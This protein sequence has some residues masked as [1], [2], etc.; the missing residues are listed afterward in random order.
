M[1]Y[2]SMI[3]RMS[4]RRLL[5]GARAAIGLCA[6]V[7]LNSS[8][9]A[10]NQCSRYV[11][12]EAEAK[13][14]LATFFKSD[15]SSARKL[16]ALLRNDGMADDYLANLQSGCASCYIFRADG[17]RPS[18]DIG[19]WYVV[20]GIAAPAAKKDVVL[21]VNCGADVRLDHTLYGG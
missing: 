20:T 6:F 17:S 13:Q 4:T 12:S 2:F 9:C 1:N 3:V 7:F 16:I 14:A 5:G 8:S 19:R 10:F 11:A 15:G 18:Y 21:Q